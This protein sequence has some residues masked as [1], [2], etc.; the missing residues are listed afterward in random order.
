MSPSLEVKANP[1]DDKSPEEPS[2]QLRKR[3]LDLN[4]L[5]SSLT[6]PLVCQFQFCGIQLKDGDSLEWHYQGH[7]AHELSRLE[8]VRVKKN[9]HDFPNRHSLGRVRRQAFERIQFRRESRQALPASTNGTQTVDHSRPLRCPCCEQM[10]QPA[11]DESDLSEEQRLHEHLEACLRVPPQSQDRLDDEN[12][13]VD[14][15]T[16]NDFE[17]YEWAGQTRV[18]ATSL[19]QGGLR[20]AGFLTIT[21]ADEDMELDVE[22]V[23]RS[24]GTAQFTDADIILPEAENESEASERNALRKKVLGQTEMIPIPRAKEDD[25]NDEDEDTTWSG[26]SEAACLKRENQALKQVSKCNVCMDMYRTPLVSVCCWHVH[27]QQCWLRALGAKKLCPQCKVI[28]TPQ[29]LRKIYL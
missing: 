25:S 8:K 4:R 6:C 24:Y 1:E 9:P 21:H 26:E 27:C 2:R 15:D 11:P 23:E 19:I 10:V 5:S 3:K 17:E 13:D 22:N 20:G 18:R 28:V 29:D 12:E 16:S 14:V 7:L